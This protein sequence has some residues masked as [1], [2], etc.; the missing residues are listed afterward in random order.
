MFGNKTESE[1]IG[2][3]IR[4]KRTERGWM[5]AKLADKIKVHYASISNWERGDSCPNALYLVA[6]ADVFECTTDELCGRVICQE[7][8]DQ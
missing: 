3:N 1:I 6:L 5:Q 8:M 4:E 2:E 7:Q